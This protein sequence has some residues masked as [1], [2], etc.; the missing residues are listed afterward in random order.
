MIN[1]IIIINQI[2]G[3]AYSSNFKYFLY[4]SAINKAISDLSIYFNSFL[5]LRFF[6]LEDNQPPFHI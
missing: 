5:L 3:I 4:S 6:I 1:I 2:N